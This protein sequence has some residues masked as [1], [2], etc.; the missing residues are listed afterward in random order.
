MMVGCFVPIC[1][2]FRAQESAN[3]CVPMLRTADVRS[4]TLFSVHF[5]FE[6]ASCSF[7]LCHFD[8]RDELAAAF[9]ATE[10]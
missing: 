1:T 9:P 2:E 8:R 6:E 10:R 5:D 3:L 4:D 7:R